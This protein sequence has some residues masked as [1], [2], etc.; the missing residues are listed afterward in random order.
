M[1]RYGRFIKILKIAGGSLLAMAAAMA[2]GLR[3]SSS[4][5]VITLLS[6]QDTKRE[7]LR[8]TARRLLAFLAAMV[9]GPVSFAVAGYRPLAMGIFLLMFTPLCMKWGIQEGI[10]VNT[11]LMTH[12]L[13]EGSMGMADIANEALLLF[14]GTGVGVLLNLYIPG[15]GAAIRSAQREIEE[16]FICLLRQMAL[17]LGAPQE[18]GAEDGAENRAE[19]GAEDGAENGAQPAGRGFQALEQALEQGERRAY[20]GMEN[21]LVADTRYYLAYMGLRKNQFAILCRMRD[22]F[23]RMESKPNQASV[24]AS[25]LES[26]SASFHER[27]NAPGLLDELEQ[28]KLQMKAQPLPVHRQ[29]FGSRAL[30]YLSLLELEQFLVLKKEFALGLSHEEIR[31]FWGEAEQ[32]PV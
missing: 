15:S 19:N 4:A 12:I 24:V 10:S 32:P 2:L 14:V 18:N 23:S 20:E 28:V 22:C 21:S 26:V 9:L 7:T 29:E 25:L 3:Y 27:N 5:G 1:P 30:L 11:V 16:T 31:R 6:I 17:E 8:V 13:A